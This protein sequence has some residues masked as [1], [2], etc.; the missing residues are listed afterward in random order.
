MTKQTTEQKID[1]I[2]E[3]YFFPE[4]V[5][6]NSSNDSNI[7]YATAEIKKLMIEARIETE[8]SMIDK[9]IDTY[10]EHGSLDDVFQVSDLYTLRKRVVKRQTELQSGVIEQ[11]ETKE[12]TDE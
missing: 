5:A 10:H 1:K 8:L 7:R 2:L 9:L 4:N 3:Q 6:R 11:R 12:K